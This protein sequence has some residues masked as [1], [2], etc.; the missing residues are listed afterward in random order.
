MADESRTQ[1]ERMR[2]VLLAGGMLVGFC[3]AAAALPC[4][5]TRLG[6]IELTADGLQ[7]GESAV[8]SLRSGDFL[9]QLNSHQLQTCTDLVEALNEA[10]RNELAT[11]LLI[12]RDG[13]TQVAVLT[14]PAATATSA[15]PA[16]PVIAVPPASVAA[17]STAPA[18]TVEP[19]KVA[20]VQ[21]TVIPPS[22]VPTPP[23]TPLSR[24][25][26]D[27]A[28]QFLAKLTAFGNELQAHQPL[29]KAQ[30]W[31]QRVERLRQDFNTARRRDTAVDVVEPI[32]GYY[33]T[34]TQIL[35]YKEDA[36]RER[37]EIRIKADVVLEYHTSSPVGA[38]L[39]RYPFLRASVIREP[40]AIHFITAGETNG[41]WLPDRAISLLVEN[42][43]SDGA[44]LSA[45]LG[46]D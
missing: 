10:R 28:R 41:Q 46:T 20:A 17:Q 18:A 30:P 35:L 32:L 39:Q 37:R 44:V 21:P 11:L 42:A 5:D 43:L 45:R 34:V 33:E 7:V 8:Q 13:A 15:A 25:D 23:P 9:V 38:W 14:A 27:T 4:A 6:Q 2:R 1:L 16:G 29:P 19:A 12:R 31:T 40:E 26:A 24:A 3:G 22:A 36:T